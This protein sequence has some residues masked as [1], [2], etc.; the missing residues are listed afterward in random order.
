MPRAGK[1]ISTLISYAVDLKQTLS[2]LYELAPS[3]GKVNMDTQWPVMLRLCRL[4]IA[5]N[6]LQVNEVIRLTVRC[7]PESQTLV[8]SLNLNPMPSSDVASF[9]LVSNNTWTMAP[10]L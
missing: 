2:A 9:Q 7:D 1:L 5:F 4:Y 10:T 6:F 3:D 8:L